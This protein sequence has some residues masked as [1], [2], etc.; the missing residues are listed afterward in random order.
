MMPV[1]EDR[2]SSELVHLHVV[3]EPVARRTTLPA[4]LTAIIGRE[5]DVEI[6]C[7]MLRDEA[8]RLLTMTGPGGVGK[9]SLSVRVAQVI[10]PAFPD[11][12]CFVPLASVSEASQVP[13]AVAKALSVRESGQRAVEAGISTLLRDKRML[14][15]L[16][17]FEHVLDAA[18]FV[19][20]LLADAP[21]LTCLVSSRAL[22]R[23]S[24][25]HDLPVRPLPLPRL[26]GVED[27][28]DVAGAP[29]VQLFVSR[30]RAVQPDF[31][32]TP[33]NAAQVATICRLV[34]GLPL[35]IELAA[36]RI[37]HFSPA[38]L[39]DRLQGTRGGSPLS[40]LVGGP[41]DAPVRHRSLRDTIAWSYDL[42]E[43]GERALFCALT[44]FV[45]GFTL[46]AAEA[47]VSGMGR[48]DDAALLSP[49]SLPAL[50]D[51]IDGISSLVDKSLLEVR[52][53][54]DG[55]TRYDF[56]ETIRDFGLE[57]LRQSGDEE[58]CR[59]A[60][61]RYF[62][63]LAV[64]AADRLFGSEQY[65][66]WN[67][68]EEEHANL[69]QA[70]I[71]FDERGDK[72]LIRLANALLFFWWYQGHLAEGRHWLERALDHADDVADA[73]RAWAAN[74]AALLTLN[75]GDM[76]RLSALV[77]E[78]ERSSLAARDLAA[79]GMA[80]MISA[81]VALIERRQTDA[82]AAC[83]RATDLLRSAGSDIWLANGLG[84]IGLILAEAGNRARGIGFVE[85]ALSLDRARGNRYFAAVRLSDLGLLSHQAGNERKA[86]AQ[87]AESVHLL[88]ADGGAWY[89]MSP[90]AG[91][92]AI[93][94]RANPRRCARLLGAAAAMR[95]RSGQPGWPYE[96]DRDE[97]AS[98]DARRML[99]DEPFE[100]AWR[101]GRAMSLD[102]LLR[103]VDAV[104]AETFERPVGAA[105][106][107]VAAGLSRR[108]AEVLSLLVAGKSDRE[109]ADEL[110]I[111][112]RTA[113][114]HVANILGK[115]DVST[116]GEAAV[117]AVRLGLV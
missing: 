110:F 47:V 2:G 44:S 81:W 66:W 26:D 6:A 108:E 97:Q 29:A 54:P 72:R 34:D 117:R 20:E 99:G 79:A 13:G 61:A 112:P 8:I 7:A 5:Q 46:D 40:L 65:D 52:Q 55:G 53:T 56:V 98:A 17:N 12:I 80:T 95:E 38:S 15:V 71:W 48:T 31:A 22:L 3:G 27:L 70:L 102:D 68:L 69:R 32:L 78:A 107:W 30:A 83:E 63:N 42:L 59:E 16:D 19:A 51:V 89:L 103:D 94:V 4:P 85:E 21:L 105:E 36:S 11:G 35:A 109:I 14:L 49:H 96:R 24:A 93:A 23:I 101:T 92:A 115:L 60:H 74:G 90:V 113:S 84:D 18:P 58:T 100:D 57:Q 67:R 77:R 116:R 9:T 33:A 86:A 41:R 10:E 76:P 88:T 104:L 111:S 43:P 1:S 50:P 25:E 73:G 62:L 64:R 75:F 91:L 106:P 82:I 114:K 39:L 45:G 87:Y 37:R 28:R